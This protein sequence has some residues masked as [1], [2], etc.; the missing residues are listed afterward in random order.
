MRKFH[1]P[2]WSEPIPG[3]S[4]LESEI[5]IISDAQVYNKMYRVY[6]PRPVIK[7]DDTY[8]LIRNVRYADDLLGKL[9][10]V[11]KHHDVYIVQPV[12]RIKYLKRTSP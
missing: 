7:V 11:L 9:E 1:A 10:F 6:H 8:Y 2:E 12:S 5:D 3:A 4:L